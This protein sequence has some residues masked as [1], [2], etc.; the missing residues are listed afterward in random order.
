MMITSSRWRLAA[1]V[2]PLALAL[3][4]AG[5]T[6]ASAQ[7]EQVS[8]LAAAT[9]AAAQETTAQET[10]SSP[11]EE[12][13]ET[14][15]AIV[16]TG[17][18]AALQSAVGTKKRNEQIVE[19][20]S[21]EDIGKLPDQS[22]A[23]SIAR[24]PG[25]AAQR[26]A[27]SGR[28]S[29]LS[30]RGLGPDFSTTTLNGRLQTS[31]GDVRNVEFDQ[32]PSEIVSGV[33]IYKTPNASLIGQ[34][35]V[36][37]VDIKTIRPLNYKDQVIAIGAKGIYVDTGKLNPDSEE[38]GYRFNGTFIDKMADDRLGIAL[39]A[40][41]AREPYQVKEE[42]AWGWPTVTT[43]EGDAFALGGLATW[44]NSTIV[45]RLGLTGTLQ[46][47]ISPEWTATID[48]FY[49]NFKDDQA[50]RGVEL[51]LVWGGA[52]G[53][54][55][56]IEDG[57]VTSGTFTNVPSV[58]NNHEFKRNSDL[59]S[60]GGNIAYDGDNG[61]KGSFDIGWSKTDRREEI[62]ETNG[63]TGFQS[64]G[65]NDT[66]TVEF[67]GDR[68]VVTDHLINYGDPAIIL[69]TDPNGWGGGA[70]NGRQ[71]GYLNNRIV[72]DE[73]IQL[74]S[75]LEREFDNSFLK[76]ISGGISYVT[77]DKSLTPDEY[78]LELAN[79][80]TQAQVPAEFLLD[81][82]DSWVGLGP[83]ITYDARGLLN[84]GFFNAL[85]NTTEGVLAKAFKLKEKI[86]SVFLMAN[87]NQE[88]GSGV[89]TGNIGV[90]AEHTDQQS[91][92]YLVTAASGLQPFSDGDKFWDVLP[93]A[94]L[95][96]RFHNDFVIR[97]AAA[98]EIMRPRMDDMAANFSY[99]FDTTR[100]IISG[101]SGNPR[102]RPYRAWAADLS[103]EKY[104]GTRGYLALQFFWK[105]L[106]SFIYRQTTE[107]DWSGFPQPNPLAIN[108]I[109]EI[110]TPINAKGGKIYGVELG[111]TIPFETFSPALEGF[112]ITG[113]VS[114]TKPKVKPDAG[115]PAEDIPGY[116]RWVANGTAYFE[117]YGFSVR[118][119]VRHRS[120]YNGDFS[121]FGATRVRRR[122]KAE[123]IIDG[124]IGYDFQ[125]GSSL[126]GLSIFLQGLNLTDE[127]LV[128]HEGF[129]DA[130]TLNYEE[131][132]R[133]FM[134]GA[135]YK[136]G[137]RV[138]PLPPPPAAPPP[139]PP[140]PP[141]T[142]TCPDGSVVLATDA[143]PAPPPPPP[144]PPPA[145][146]RG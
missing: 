50:R 92:G 39:S 109:G 116:S 78:Y 3:S 80:A 70:P 10:V 136:F 34:G 95:N 8:D 64:A 88:Y 57:V 146:E 132:G 123:T 141:A 86:A 122:I 90:R 63:G 73:I 97:V 53:T 16:V 94:N 48:A 40:S 118:G 20:V 30:I 140:P 31:T 67:R 112:G 44:N 23:E 81:P 14:D 9:A 142:Q 2:S 110:S 126:Q 138:A 18:R 125:P 111:G 42:R 51:P 82:I 75:Q 22:I 41:Y 62:L 91:D 98:R 102:L 28:T 84:S 83:V 55:N 25:L 74:A 1:A 114:Y 43:P 115:A 47:E 15:D 77:R 4:F 129:N 106:D 66:V 121:G 36:G 131:Y 37:S 144:P 124:Q 79:G 103:L 117:K 5:T 35:L 6:P 100:G 7:T 85:P 99:G 11:T 127:P 128:S 26:I 139:P 101:S 89:L 61:W 24:L 71:M 107:F 113:G 45:K 96:F 54:A 130:L 13:T 108:P 72:D 27:G 87:L 145:P 65:A 69:I 52:G 33:D 12:A 60:V 68:L 49:S 32:Y 56:T 17:F 19:S 46:Y 120:S 76:S 105:D 135:T 38:Y 59:Y 93:S 104:W 21:A 119:S 29:Y 137:A 133:R 143:C 58:V 134:L